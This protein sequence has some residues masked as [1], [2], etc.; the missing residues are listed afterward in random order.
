MR[1][2]RATAA[3]KT[4]MPPSTGA[5]DANGSTARNPANEVRFHLIR[6]RPWGRSAAEIRDPWKKTRVWLG[7][8]D[9]V[10]DAARAYDSGAQTLRRASTAV[11]PL[12]DSS[13]LSR[14][15]SFSTRPKVEFG[16]ETGMTKM[17]QRG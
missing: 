4:V 7:T 16:D 2:A 14:R 13:R 12:R 5:D 17:S 11:A 8:F 15:R 1:R 9:S 3:T 6:K 10:E